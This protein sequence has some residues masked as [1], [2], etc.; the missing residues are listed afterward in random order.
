[1]YIESED[2]V[3]KDDVEDDK[4]NFRDNLKLAV[5]HSSKNNRLNYLIDKHLEV[6]TYFDN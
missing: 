3:P 4:L 2:A 5:Q 1:M 6:R